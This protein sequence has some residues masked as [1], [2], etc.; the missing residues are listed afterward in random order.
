M[1]YQ[2]DLVADMALQDPK[3]ILASLRAE[4][5]TVC[6]LDRLFDGWPKEVNPHLG[7]LRQDIDAWL[8]R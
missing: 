7:Q 4:T 2:E 1:G 5:I 8:E 6:N 3:A